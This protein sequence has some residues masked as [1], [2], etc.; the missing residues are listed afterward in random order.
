MCCG[1]V[2]FMLHS[3]E[4]TS[5]FV[6]FG[7]S[8]HHDATLKPHSPQVFECLSCSAPSVTRRQAG[9]ELASLPHTPAAD[10]PCWRRF[11]TAVTTEFQNFVLPMTRTAS[12]LSPFHLMNR[13][14]PHFRKVIDRF[15]E[16][17]SLLSGG[18]SGCFDVVLRALRI[19][20][21][22]DFLDQVRQ[23][24]S[25]GRNPCVTKLRYRC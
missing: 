12:I 6:R 16:R 4:T 22:A 15:E 8:I 21:Q 3:P 24:R 19:T 20:L 10:L 2:D 23:L 18:E 14:V 7:S 11:C 13:V 25:H 9:G 5:L 17:Q 1:S